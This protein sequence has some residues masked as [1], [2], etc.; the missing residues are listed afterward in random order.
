VK[1]SI[2][3]LLLCLVPS[4]ALAQGQSGSI[5]G[6]VKDSSGAVLPGVTVEVASPALIEKVRTAV[7]D[8][9]GAYKIIDLG[10]GTYSVTFT[11]TGF[12]TVKREGIELTAAFTAPVNAEMKVGAVA[13]TITVSGESPIVDTQNVVQKT[14]QN[15]EAMD[16]LPT[17]RNFVSFAAMQPGVYVSAVSQNV[18]GSVPETGMNMTVHGS[19]ANDSLVMVNGMPIING[20]GSGGL[21]YGNYMNNS[22]MEEIT[23]QTAGNNAEFERASVYSNMILKDGGNMFNGSFQGRFTNTKLESNNLDATQIS[24]GLKSPFLMNKIWDLNPVVGLPV[25]KDR[26]WLYGGYRHWG[27][28]NNVAGSFKDASFTE[29]LYSCNQDSAGNCTTE[30]NLFPVW[31]QSADLHLTTQVTP[32]NK[33]SAYYDWQ[34]TDFG[35]CFQPNYLTAISACAESKNIPQYVVAANWSSP[36]S[37]KLLLEAGYLITAQD[38]HGYRQPGVPTTVFSIN[39]PLAPAGMPQTWGS[40]T[41]YGYNRSNQFNYRASVSYVTG[42]HNVKVGMSLMHQ[43]RFQTQEPNNSVSLAL[44][45]GKPFQLTEYATPIQFHETVGYNQG[46]YAQ[47][48]WT[49]KRLTMNYG[50]RLDMLNANVDAQELAAGPFTPA[51]SY[52]AVNNVPNWKDINPRFG[53]AY[54]LFGDGK[55][56]IKGSIGRYALADSYTIARALNPENVTVNTT[57]RNWNADPSGQL[58]PFLDCNLANPAANG[59]CG[60]ILSPSF[61]TQVVT[62]NYD[63]AITQGWGVR[64]ANWEAQIAV[65]QQIVP[66]V[67]VYAGY[68]RRWYSNL[69]GTQNLAVTND[70]FTAFCIG[71]PSAPGI[72]GVT[73]PNAGGQ[74][75]GFTDLKAPTTANNL[76]QSVNNLGSI[77]DHFDGFDF[78]ANARLGRGIFV[79]GGLSVGREAYNICSLVG[80]YSITGVSGA[81]AGLGTIGAG[82]SRTDQAFCNV[83][84]PF[85]PNVKGQISYPLPWH[86]TVAGTFQSLPGAQISGNYPLSNTTPGLTLGRNFT[87]APTAAMVAP[88]TM[89]E[90]RLYQTD[91]RFSGV[92]RVGRTTIRP[93]FSVYNLFNSNAVNTNNPFNATYGASWLAPVIILTPRFADV[94]VQVNF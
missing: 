84:P 20:S 74:E 56:A 12:S 70:S 23:F 15:R 62:T 60:P 4:L 52:P 78:D 37:N 68:A 71:V 11:L 24:Q 14:T 67:S 35:N 49:I 85:Q 19:R 16:A 50:V 32:R 21:Q 18:G 3:L 41:T 33:L 31:H 87:S 53:A 1:S 79:S 13:E 90:D 55:T 42:S 48:Q 2:V 39:D 59:S 44:R 83:S 30:Q 64:P 38:F 61:G 28:Y 73:L 43:W 92:F 75:C 27:T 17:D 6:M 93:N 9:Q 46:W 51:R 81:G 34:Y 65:Q 5:A 91:I 69:W 45:A 25:I 88:G 58:N 10:P 89:Y 54:D 29:T 76:V 80:N 47:D 57:A 22:M 86:L 36:V 40:A 7:T 77:S 8:G 63:P 94:G 72:T 26:V 82:V 66:R